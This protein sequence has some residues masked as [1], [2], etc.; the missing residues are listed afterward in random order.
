MFLFKRTKTIN[1]FIYP[2]LIWLLSDYF[3]ASHTLKGKI[4]AT[5]ITYLE[6]YLVESDTK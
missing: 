6:N 5:F 2:L 3:N 4:T 1:C